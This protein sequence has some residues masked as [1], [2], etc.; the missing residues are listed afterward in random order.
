M[1]NKLL[2]IVIIAFSINLLLNT[3]CKKE[4]P[5]KLAG[6]ST[7]PATNITVSEAT[8]G[9]TITSDGGATIISNGVCWGLN[10]NP[11][12]NDSKT[13]DGNSV[14]Q[15]V[16]NLS[17]LTGG[18]T[19]HIRAYATNSVGT[20]YGADLS[21]TTLGLA[22]IGLTQAATNISVS[23][24]TLNGTVNANY[25]ST[26][27]TFEYGTST[28]YGQTV[29]SSQSPVTGNSITNV[30]ASISGLTAGVTYHF[31]IKTVNSLGTTYGDDMTFT[32]S[33]QAPIVITQAACCFSSTGATLNGTVNPNL[34]ST[35]VSF[36]YG[37]TTSY[38][39]SIA[40]NPAVLTG[41]TN[42]AVS[43]II[44]SLTPGTTYHF[45]VKAV[46]SLGTVYGSDMTFVTSGESPIATTLAATNIN[47]SS[48]TLNGL[49]NA[50]SLS[51]VVTFEY[52]TT[53]NYG[54]IATSVQ[55]PVLGN[56]DTNVNVSV[57]GLNPG[58]TYHFRV[59]AVNSVG[60][61]Y[62]ADMNFVTLGQQPV[63][64]TQSVTNITTAGATLN[65][66]INP[67]YLSTTV[68]FE[69]GTTTGYGQS[70]SANPGVLTGSVSVSTNSIVTG[71]A[72][73][74]TY[75]FRVKAVNSLGTVNGNDMTF[76]TLGGA[77][78]AGTSAA[79]NI[80]SP[81]VT[82]NGWV[83]ANN[84]STSV[85]FEYGNSTS[86][87]NTVTAVQSPLTGNTVTNVAATISGLTVGA[88][89][90]FRVRA[91]NSLGIVYGNDMS[92]IFNSIADIDGNVYKVVI[93]GNQIWM[94]DNL[95]TIRYNDGTAIP[96]VTDH[97]SWIGI[98]A[99]AYCDYNN[100]SS[101]S[102]TYGRLYN[103]YAVDNN[104]STRGASNGGKNVC[105]TGWH[106]PSHAEWSTLTDY[107]GGF[108]IAGGKLKEVGTIHWIS[109]NT[110]ATDES[111]FTALPAGAHGTE[112]NFAFMGIYAYWWSTDQTSVSNAWSPSLAY[113]NA[114]G[115]HPN[116]IKKTDGVSIRCIKDN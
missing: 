38:G 14:G 18:T 96:N 31:R 68:T 39:N 77:P 22:P 5:A 80:Y 27:V 49:V 10:A 11:S 8:S 76:T 116:D 40:A 104:L 91:S 95:K 98:T 65:A 53:T 6:V 59:K 73:G 44:A 112:V 4:D 89:Y 64:S 83:N 67:N 71:L 45:R 34:I 2:S 3:S 62:G 101:N 50:T 25:L 61:V 93:I 43:A 47:T 79:T 60:T 41:N 97:A 55:S 105:P 30:S 92:F 88:T 85:I 54:S 58:T 113:N 84:L 28:N 20:A 21:F 52:G 103:W 24:A 86:Y 37:L 87:G 114:T 78:S 42:S 75:H 115:V 108:D 66:S 29:T 109:P 9:G 1:K 70:V 94:A 15:F 13:V 32:T 111:G 81:T 51:T 100:N 17:G 69:Y 23:S 7:T 46:N 82:L 26:T 90:H 33:G 63:V 102:M 12:I 16:S 110:G 99:G 107:L 72:P 19:Y 56:T 35:T 74:T 57:T 36:E 106:V 48:V